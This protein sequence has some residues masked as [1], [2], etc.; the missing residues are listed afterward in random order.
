LSP[1]EEEARTTSAHSATAAP[2]PAA[3]SGLIAAPTPFNGITSIR[4]TLAA[5]SRVDLAVFD[6]RGRRVATLER[7]RLA[8][9]HHAVPWNVARAASGTYLVRLRADDHTL[10]TK[11]SLV[12]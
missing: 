4:F 6:A 8:A 5:P 9:G 7:G 3:S 1:A 10:V 12:E 2:P 11:I